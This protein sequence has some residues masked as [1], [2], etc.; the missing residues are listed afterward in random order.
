MEPV[1]AVLSRDAIVNAA[2]D[3]IERDGV[4][5]LSM[6]KVAARLGVAAMSLYH[7]V[8]NK[9]ALVD[10][11]VE[12]VV[13]DLDFADDPAADPRERARGMMRAF[14]KIAKDRPKSVNLVIT[15]T[16]ESP[17]TLRL[18]EHAMEI[19]RAAGFAGGQAARIASAFLSYVIGSLLR[20]AR[21]ARE[22][23]SGTGGDPFIRG[24]DAIDPAD[25]PN[26]TALVAEGHVYDADAEFEVGLEM[27]LRGLP[28]V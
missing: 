9:A 18:Y 4:E 24:A 16:F 13:S 2:I 23:T 21:F 19:A 20:E 17:A 5:A 14:R 27:L 3:L 6:R 7:H 25:Y 12:R 15:R 11:V 1:R 26:V 10:A 8:P 22:A 28:E